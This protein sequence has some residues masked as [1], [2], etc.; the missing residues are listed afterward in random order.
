MY[1]F[2]DDLED[3]YAASIDDISY[4]GFYTRGGNFRTYA[5]LVGVRRIGVSTGISPR[6]RSP[7]HISGLRFEYHDQRTP[8]IVGQW[9]N[10]YD[11]IELAPD[12]ALQGITVTV[13]P[14][15]DSYWGY[16]DVSEGFDIEEGSDGDGEPD[17]D[18]NDESDGDGGPDNSSLGLG[19]GEGPEIGKG[20][21]IAIH[22]GTTHGQ[23]KM[24]KSS[25]SVLPP[26]SASM[27]SQYNRGPQEELVREKT[28]QLPKW[29]Y[30]LTFYVSPDRDFMGF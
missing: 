17:E 30:V 13:K 15:G 9:M 24:F 20:P 8:V 12:E 21:V 3:R 4:T 19:I 29:H 26:F 11:S 7:H 1:P 5:P 23:H 6:S 16:V 10:E 27:V 18:N 2:D 22:I 25:E 14:K 28:I